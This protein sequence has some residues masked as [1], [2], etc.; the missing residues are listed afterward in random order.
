[1]K[2][3]L[4]I[5]CLVCGQKNRIPFSRLN[6]L[7]LCGR[8]GSPIDELISVCLECGTKNR[9]PDDRLNDR[10]ICGKCGVPL[11]HGDVVSVDD[12]SFSQEIM[13][14]PGPVLVCFWAPWC[15]S[16]RT[17]M[18]LLEK[19]ASRY[20][21]GIRIA[22]LNIENNSSIPKKYGIEHTPSFLFFRDGQLASKV[23]GVFTSEA[24]EKK[25][26]AIFK[27]NLESTHA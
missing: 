5:R 17:T 9:I 15:V 19:L 22:R 16:S 4:I 20:G 1:M 2:N 12:Q 18:P 23:E 13:S 24:I 7:P 6:D 26:H 27:K 11:Y 21:G 10:P 3:D 8:C 14:F 25:L